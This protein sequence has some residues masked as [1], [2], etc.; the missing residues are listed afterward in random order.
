MSFS[1]I[2]VITHL[3]VRAY[4]RTLWV[5]CILLFWYTSQKLFVRWGSSIS[6]NFGMSN[7]IRQG[8][9]LSPYLFNIYVDE[10]NINLK[11][12]HVGCHVSGVCTNNFSYA[13]DL[14]LIGPDAK[15]LNALV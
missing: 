4:I 9:C 5:S 7:G 1:K 14:V 2:G 13:D 15:S 10:L 6:D 8:S 11:N 3:G 12:S